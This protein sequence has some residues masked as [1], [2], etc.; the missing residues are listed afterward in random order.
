MIQWVINSLK[1]NANYIFIV[2]KEHQV[3]FNI[4]SVLKILKTKL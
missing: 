3:K 1:I 4:K 2:Q